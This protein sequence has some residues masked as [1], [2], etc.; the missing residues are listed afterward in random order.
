M[1]EINIIE[2]NGKGSGRGY[3]KFPWKLYRKDSHNLPTLYNSMNTGGILMT[4]NPSYYTNLIKHLD[5]ERRA[6]CL[7]MRFLIT[8]MCQ[9]SKSELIMS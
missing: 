3:I 5:L 1:S 6:I 4:Y 2:V 9:T 7:P 8:P